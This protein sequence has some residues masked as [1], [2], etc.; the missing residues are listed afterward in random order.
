LKKLTPT[1]PK[2]SAL[3]GRVRQRGTGAEQAVGS[4]LRGLSIHY[5][6]NVRGLPG[7]PDFS[8]KRAR[9][10]NFVNG[11]FWHAHRGCVR[12]TVPKA[13]REFWQEKFRQNRTRDASAVQALRRVGF[14]VCIVWECEVPDARDK[15]SRFFGL[16][17]ANDAADSALGSSG[18]FRGSHHQTSGHRQDH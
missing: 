4:A 16:N 3:L 12:A 15:L 10:A 1:N 8:N 14:R 13:N 11:C 9:W 18:L 2:Q 5:R 7:A 6:K 17:R